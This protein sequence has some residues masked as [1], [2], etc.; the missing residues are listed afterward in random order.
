[1]VVT[2]HQDLEQLTVDL[3]MVMSAARLNNNNI[4]SQGC[5]YHNNSQG[6]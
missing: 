1:M 5:I 6:L 2:R 3:G 4:V